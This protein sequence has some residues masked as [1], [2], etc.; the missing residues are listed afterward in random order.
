MVAHLTFAQEQDERSPL[1]VADSMQLRVQS[2][3]G[4]P[5]MAGNIPFLRRLAAVLVGLQ[6]RGIDHDA[7]RFG[8]FTGEAGKDAVEHA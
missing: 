5:D 2:A 6:M 3:F 1:L 8:A 7:F 4:S